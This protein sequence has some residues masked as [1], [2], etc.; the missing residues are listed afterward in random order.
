MLVLGENL[1]IHHNPYLS[2]NSKKMGAYHLF[3]NPTKKEFL[4]PAQ[5][6][7]GNKRYALFHGL[8]RYALQL[9]FYSIDLSSQIITE[10]IKN[11]TGDV[12]Y[13]AADNDAPNQA[14]AE[15][16]QQIVGETEEH[17]LYW[18]ARHHYRDISLPLLKYFLTNDR[19]ED[20]LADFYER[21]KIH[22]HHFQFMASTYFETKNALLR[23][24]LEKHFGKNWMKR[25]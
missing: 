10:D 15:L 25:L 16:L 8:H 18:H 9:L 2:F 22:K 20:F 1:K 11:W 7:D 4:D 23:A 14:S 6:G 12:M 19:D 21:A 5:F 17:N 13:I 3:V 24:D